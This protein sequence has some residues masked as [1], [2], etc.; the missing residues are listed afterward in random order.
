MEFIN[1]L[2][3]DR[4]KLIILIVIILL[5]PIALSLAAARFDISKTFPTPKPVQ[6]K[7]KI[8]YTP[9]PAVEPNL[10]EGPYSCPSV[11]NFCTNGIEVVRDNKYEGIGANIPAESP[12]YAAF[13][14]TVSSISGTLSAELG[15]ENITTI[16]LDNRERGLRAV[17]TY[18]GEAPQPQDVK[19]GDTI[20]RMGDKVNLY[21][22]PLVFK[23]IKGDPLLGE[24]V[25]LTS[26]DFK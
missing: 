23:L 5:L 8:E 22:V 17:Y 25:K 18:R 24:V 11:T 4:Q 16:Y 13:S 1:N 20:A 6:K 14:G 15:G 2:L 26:E 7:V 3:R 19:E 12:I 21:G 10:Q 9:Q